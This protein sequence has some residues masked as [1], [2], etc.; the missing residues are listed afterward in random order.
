MVGF[1]GL[2]MALY[3]SLNEHRRAMAILREMGVGPR[4]IAAL[5]VL[6]SGAL[7]LLGGLLGVGLVYGLFLILPPVVEDR[8][9]L[10]IPLRALSSVAEGS[11][12]ATLVAGCDLGLVSALQAYRHTVVDGLS[13]H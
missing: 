6:A 9:G 12:L 8:F 3:T 2:L 10:S 1:L 13:M 4:N 5:L 11:A 7:G